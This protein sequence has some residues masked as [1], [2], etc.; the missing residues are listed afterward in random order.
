[1]PVV[2]DPYQGLSGKDRLIV[3]AKFGFNYINWINN[4]KIYL[5]LYI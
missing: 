3:N 4:Y 1:M 2:L 5:L